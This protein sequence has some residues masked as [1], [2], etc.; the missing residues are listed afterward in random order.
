MEGGVVLTDNFELY[1][2]MLSLRA[3]GWTRNLG[4]DNPLHKKSNNKFIESFNFILPGYN[5]RP[6]ELSGAIGIEQLKKLSKAR[7][8]V[9]HSFP[10]K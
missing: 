5:L 8:V 6:L 7:I 9:R 1:N 2:I 4:I 3:H 10:D